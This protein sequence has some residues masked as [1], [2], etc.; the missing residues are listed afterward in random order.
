VEIGEDGTVEVTIDTAFAKEVHGDQDHA[1]RIEVE[2]RDESRRTIMGSGQVLAARKPFKVYAWIDRGY[3]KVGDEI[4]ASFRAFTLDQKPVTGK[5]KV[6]LF[7]ITYDKDGKPQEGAEQTWDLDTNDRGEADLKMRATRAGQYRLAYKLTYSKGHTEEG[8]YL[9]VI[10]GEGFDGSEFRFNNLELITDSREYKPGDKAR[11]MINTNRAGSSV[12]Y[13]LRPSNGIYKDPKLL[14]L[15]GKSTIEE[16]AVTVKDM[17]NFF[18]EAMTVSNGRIHREMREIVVPPEKRVL[19]V[20]VMPSADTYKPGE[21]ANVRLAIKDID[22]RPYQGCLALTVYDKALEY[23]SG[24]SN[25]PEI[26]SYFWKWRRHHNPSEESNLNVYYGYSEIFTE[27][28]MNYLG[29]FGH[30]VADM[31]DALAEGD[32]FMVGKGMK[33]EAG[34]ERRMRAAADESAPAVSAPVEMEE[35][36]AQ[37]GGFA[38]EKKADRDNGLGGAAEPLVEPTIRKEFADTAF[39]A[40]SIET[41]EDGFAEVSFDMPENLSAWKIKTWAM[42]HGTRVGEGA[43]EV[44]TTKNLLLRLQAPRFFVERDEV[45]LSANIHNYLERSK[46]VKAVLELDGDTIEF[47]DDAEQHITLAAGGEMRVDWRVKV[48]REGEAVVRMKALSDEESDAMEMRFPVYVHGMARTE[49]FSGAM[50]SDQALATLSFNVPEE[51]R[52]NESLLEIRFSPTLAGAMVD[53]LPYLAEYPYGCTEQTLNRFVPTVITQKVLLDMGITLAD[54][55]E[56]KVNLNAQEIGDPE[57]PAARWKVWDRNPIYNEYLLKDMVKTGLRRLT[58][59]QLSDGGWGWFSGWGERSYPHTTAVVVHGLQTARHNDL[60][61][62]PGVIERGI[63]WLE[64][65]QAAEIQKLKNAE[66]EIRPYK[67][68]A[69]NMDAY[70]Y[71]VL[72]DEGKFNDD[73]RTFLYRD[74]KNLSLYSKAMFGLALFNEGEKAKLD[75]IVRNIEQYVVYDDENQTTWLTLPGHGWWYWYGSEY[76]TLAY[77]LKL[78]AKVD[79][80]SEKASGLA[81]YLINNRRHGTYWNSTRDT[82]LCIEAL[83]DYMRASGEDRPDMQLEI[84]I[85]GRKYKDVKID[86]SNL[87][88]FD[89]TLLL[90]GDA[91]EGGDHVV[92]FRKTGKGPLYFNA[93]LTCFTLEDYIERAGLEIKVNR[94]VYKL[95]PKDKQIDAAGSRGQVVKQKV[96]KYERVLLENLSTLKS[97]DLVEIELLIESKNDYEYLI[98]ED[99]KAAGFEPVDVRSGYIRSGVHAYMEL[100]DESVAFFVRFLNRGKHSVSYRVRAEIPGKFSALPTRAYAMYAPE[101]RGNSD[102]IK[103]RIED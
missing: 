58:N 74:R 72:G 4:R 81:K 54:I 78:L 49:S 51:R 100:H 22:G 63:E 55:R 8:G 20:K 1:Y 36:V 26:R 94:N 85:D 83:A 57:V 25:V 79:P 99:M 56:K 7:K 10:R 95:I 90:K 70:V 5:G 9:F 92:E 24:G 14:K 68:R 91:V 19:D 82:A 33:S 23:I 27:P 13:F 3:Y 45:V 60:A 43:A 18:V 21:A 32:G 102:E 62:V 80:K 34:G 59:M 39:W 50:R 6:T 17:P 41:D 38:K 40:A 88:A 47:M 84:L 87:F 97:G 76:E 37:V 64:R 46:A 96:E 16:I 42:G 61:L 28:G 77:Y 75:M 44:I 65:Y 12:W 101:L 2:V 11:L 52:I 71:M 66:K 35:S 73:M 89:G 98:F 15:D 103:L 67:H 86:A 69:D 48:V 29:V 53:A 31:K 93:Y 30:M